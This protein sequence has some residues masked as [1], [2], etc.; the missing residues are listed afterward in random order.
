MRMWI[1]LDLDC[2][3]AKAMPRP[4]DDCDKIRLQTSKEIDHE[5]AWKL[6]QSYCVEDTAQLTRPCAFD[7]ILGVGPGQEPSGRRGRGGTRGRGAP[8]SRRHC[9]ACAAPIPHHHHQCPPKCPPSYTHLGSA[10]LIFFPC[11]LA[12]VLGAAA[13]SDRDGGA[14][15]RAVTSSEALIVDPHSTPPTPAILRFHIKRGAHRRSA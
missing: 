3:A 14:P 12:G 7:L 6:T 5:L 4:L 15:Y 13:A 9:G 10:C 8:G 1:S 2:K 11:P